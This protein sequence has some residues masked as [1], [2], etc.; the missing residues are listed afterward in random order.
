MTKHPAQNMTILPHFKENLSELCSNFKERM[1]MAAHRRKPKGIK[2]VRFEALVF[3]QTT[4]ITKVM[5]Y[6]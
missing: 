6:H 2:I 3:P 5:K 4:K 1:Q